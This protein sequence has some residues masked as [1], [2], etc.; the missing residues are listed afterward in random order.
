MR[1][2]DTKWLRG[3][4]FANEPLLGTADFQSPADMGNSFDVIR[5]IGVV[6][7]VRQDVVRLVAATLVPILPLGLTMMPFEDL[8]KTLIG[9]IV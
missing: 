8:V 5:E 4:A 1:E 7:I 6:P 9:I 2:F 3:G